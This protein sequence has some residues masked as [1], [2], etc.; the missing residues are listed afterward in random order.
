MVSHCETDSR[1]ENYVDILRKYINVD[2]LGAC[3]TKWNCGR[4]HNHAKGDCFDIL[5]S[6]YRYYLAFENALC[7]EYIS[8]KFFENYDYDII[9]VVRGGNPKFRP[10]DI[11]RDAYISANDFKTAHDL[12][13][14]LK[15]LSNDTKM[16]ASMLK[17]KDK[18]QAVPYIDLFQK[19]MCDICKRLQNPTEYKSVYADIREW[20]LSEEPCFK[21]NDILN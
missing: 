13:R 15:S 12:G 5:N 17:A 18:Y 16:Y 20:M 14:F 6:T 2:I 7:D 9:Q 19:A 11:K 3:G 4:R 8:E 21:P 1:R 10:I